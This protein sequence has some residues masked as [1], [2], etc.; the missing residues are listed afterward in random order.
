MEQRHK[1]VLRLQMN[2][3]IAFDAFYCTIH[4]PH[5]D[6]SE[7][8]SAAKSPICNNSTSK[9][10]SAFGGMTPPAPCVP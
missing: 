9:S 3:T 8:I 10:K 2:N 5:A 6:F 4:A 1:R 7:G